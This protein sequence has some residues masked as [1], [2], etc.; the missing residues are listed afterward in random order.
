MNRWLVVRQLNNNPK[1][2]KVGTNPHWGPSCVSNCCG[3]RLF[4]YKSRQQILKWQQVL[5]QNNKA[6]KQVDSESI[7]DSKYHQ[8]VRNP[9]QIRYGPSLRRIV[10]RALWLTGALKWIRTTKNI[11]T[12]IMSRC[13]VLIYL[14]TYYLVPFQTEVG[15][16]P[17]TV[18]MV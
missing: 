4:I 10:C 17:V 12:I 5:L 3:G 16:S 7:S 18:R 8:V 13:M 14:A 11:A 2:K 9:L 15:G 1:S 6:H